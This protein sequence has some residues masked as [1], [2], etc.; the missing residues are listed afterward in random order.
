MMIATQSAGDNVW[1]AGGAWTWSGFASG[2]RFALETMMPAM[3]AASECGFKNI[4]FTVWG[5]FGKECSYYSILPAL[6]TAKKVYEGI[7]DID[8]IKRLFKE[9]TGED[10]DHMMDL[11]IPNYVGGNKCVMGNVSKHMLYSDPFL[12]FLDSTVK[13]GVTEEYKEHAKLLRSHGEGSQFKY[14]Y[15]FLAS[16]C[17]L[18]SYKYDLGKKTRTIYKAN[19]KE[20][21]KV[22]IETYDIVLEKLEVFYNEFINVWFTECKPNGFEVHDIK[23]GGLKQRLIHCKARLQDYLNGTLT[24][25]PE[26][27][28]EIL[29]FYGGVNEYKEEPPYLTSWSL[30]ALVTRI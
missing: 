26:L 17:D 12:G 4:L 29:D 1:F 10:Y 23:L 20:Q 24:S 11:D 22:L 2:N 15:N 27:E 28:E 7:S 30:A 5:D 21:L 3:E 14:I 8:T 16:L 9:V 25:I 18:L 6:F 13:Q 19:D